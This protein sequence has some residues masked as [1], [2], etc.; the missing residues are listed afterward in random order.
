MISPSRISF[1]CCIQANTGSF[2]VSIVI[3]DNDRQSVFTPKG[4]FSDRNTAIIFIA[5][6]NNSLIVG[7]KFGVSLKL[8]W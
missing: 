4:N 7:D 1:N 6:L 2:S 3:C 5:L 8:S